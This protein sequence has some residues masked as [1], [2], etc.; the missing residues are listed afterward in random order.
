MRPAA[1]S[2]V[3]FWR[4]ALRA[5]PKSL[6]GHRP[7]QPDRRPDEGGSRSAP[8]CSPDEDL[9]L[10]GCIPPR[11]CG[12]LLLALDPRFGGLRR[13]AG[14]PGWTW[15]PPMR[16]LLGV[17]VGAGV[18]EELFDF[19]EEFLGVDGRVGPGFRVVGDIAVAVVVIVEVAAEVELVVRHHRFEP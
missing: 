12:L 17:V 11:G 6:L 16:G 4:A 15:R 13:S 2:S 5:A 10:P 18:A 3:E 8:S 1:A 14:S 19:G 9:A 7:A